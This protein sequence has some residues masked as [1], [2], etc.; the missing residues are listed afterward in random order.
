MKKTASLMMLFVLA[1]SSWQIWE[2]LNNKLTVYYGDKNSQICYQ[3][4]AEDYDGHCV[5]GGTPTSQY[6]NSHVEK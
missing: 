2:S 1:A 5:I 6:Y 4:G 3:G